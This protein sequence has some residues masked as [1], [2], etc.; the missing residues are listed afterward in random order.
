MNKLLTAAIFIAAGSYYFA[1]KP[2]HM[3]ASEIDSQ[4]DVVMFT[5]SWCGYCKQARAFFA[6]KFSDQP[7][8]LCEKDIETSAAH[9]T[10][11]DDLGGRGVPLIIIG[12]EKISGYS[13]ESYQ[14]ALKT[15]EL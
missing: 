8:R 2:K 1:H 4:C 5:T 9:K 6:D 3:S 15:I 12:N 7:E 14:Q 10:L 11:F 13:L